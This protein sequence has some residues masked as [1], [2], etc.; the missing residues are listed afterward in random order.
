MLTVPELE[1]KID[2]IKP[3][4][5]LELYDMVAGLDQQDV[6]FDATYQQILE[7]IVNDLLKK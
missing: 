1:S 2:D 3:G 4:A 6:G 7:L 5:S